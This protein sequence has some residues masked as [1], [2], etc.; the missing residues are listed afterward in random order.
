MLKSD[1]ILTDR[2]MF[3]TLKMGPAQ[4]QNEVQKHEFFGSQG[5]PKNDP[6]L[7]ILT[8][9]G[10][11]KTLQLNCNKTNRKIHKFLTNLSKMSKNVKKSQKNVKKPKKTIKK[12]VF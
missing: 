3:I 6:I 2:L 5:V 9:V 11:I 8:T 12:V 4:V 10:M 7:S 1:W